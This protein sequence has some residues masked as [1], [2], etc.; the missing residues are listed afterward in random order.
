MQIV[1]TEGAKYGLRL[2]NNEDGAPIKSK[3][4]LKYL[5]ALLQK[6]GRIDSEIGA[7]IGTAKSE[8]RSLVQ[9]WNHANIC[10]RRKIQLYKSLVL[11]RLL[12]GLQTLWLSKHLRQRIDG[13]HCMCLRQILG[14]PHSYI[15]RIPNA[16]VLKKAQ[17]RPL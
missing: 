13:F 11:S 16:D 6:T 8:F 14:I 5:G 12:Y 2:N 15:S 1:A 3:A 17:E 10:I 7:K 9:I 4:S